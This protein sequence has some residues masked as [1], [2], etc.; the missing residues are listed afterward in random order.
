MVEYHLSIKTISQVIIEERRSGKTKT[1]C[2][3]TIPPSFLTK[4][5]E[6]VAVTIDA[7]P[8]SE[9]VGFNIKSEAESLGKNFKYLWEK[10]D[11]TSTF[12]LRTVSKSNY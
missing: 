8:G 7:E 1:I 2:G 6:P 11:N 5:S 3:S 9:T 4:I 12:K 10:I